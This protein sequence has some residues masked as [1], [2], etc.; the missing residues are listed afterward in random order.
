M[1][2]E[3]HWYQFNAVQEQEP[4]RRRQ[5][6]GKRPAVG[7]ALA[8]S[9]EYLPGKVDVVSRGQIPDRR[10]LTEGLRAWSLSGT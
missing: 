7:E 6:P 10:G 2:L 8:G 9:S 4:E 3:G 1:K 5:R